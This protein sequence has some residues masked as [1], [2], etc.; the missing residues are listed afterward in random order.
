MNQLFAKCLVLGLAFL[1]T[2]APAGSEVHVLGEMRRMFTAHDIGPNVEL[3]KVN[4]EP[5]LYAL[6]P[7]A[8]LQGEVTVLD[9][10]VFQSR[11][12]GKEP[13]VTTDPNIRSVFLVYACVPVWRS[14][15]IPG[16]VRTE[17]D[18]A[19]FLETKFAAN[20]R[21]AF[22]VQGTA[23][24]ARYHIQNYHGAAGELTHAA[25]DKAKM[26]FEIENSSV[27]LVGFFTNCDGDGGSF[28]HM[29]QRTHIHVASADRKQ[30][31][32]LESIELAPGARLMLP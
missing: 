10:Q 23:R 5:H 12:E 30:M 32:H 16:S 27:E 25:H 7:L 18:L 24:H 2:L 15:E 13:A 9:G 14:T 6:G 20:T 8:G 11:V 17:K 29:G 28:V 3:A 26:F 21:S 22:L 31:G 1:P 19:D 4:R